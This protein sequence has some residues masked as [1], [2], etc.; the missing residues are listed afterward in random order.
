[1]RG[2]YGGQ[3][4]TREEPMRNLA[5]KAAVVCLLGGAVLARPSSAQAKALGGCGPW[6]I[7]ECPDA[8]DFCGSCVGSGGP[9]CDEPYGG[10]L[11][12]GNEWHTTVVWC[13]FNS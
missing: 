3:P 1:M 5:L 11:D 6:C 8:G 12:N 4:F 13:N 2:E 10:C 9:I 7:D